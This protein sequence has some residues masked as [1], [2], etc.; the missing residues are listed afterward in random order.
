MTLDLEVKKGHRPAGCELLF[1]GSGFLQEELVTLTRASPFG[2]SIVGPV[3][4]V[5]HVF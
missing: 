5:A 1:K 3:A 4:V 2:L